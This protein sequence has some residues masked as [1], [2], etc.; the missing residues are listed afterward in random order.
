MVTARREKFPF[1]DP[2]WL[3]ENSKDP[4]FEAWWRSTGI[5]WED[6]RSKQTPPEE[7]ARRA[8]VASKENLTKRLK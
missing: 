6:A 7:I 8:W 2:L 5:G 1:P 3:Q 4:E